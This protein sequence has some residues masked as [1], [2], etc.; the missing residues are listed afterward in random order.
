MNDGLRKNFVIL[1]V[2][3]ADMVLVAEAV[4]EGVVPD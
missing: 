3:G 2:G 1:V 4:E